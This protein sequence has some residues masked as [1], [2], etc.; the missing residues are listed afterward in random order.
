MHE[1]NIESLRTEALRLIKMEQQLFAEMLASDGVITEWGQEFKT[2]IRS[3][4][5]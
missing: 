5:C 3:F 4:E 1:N 2:D